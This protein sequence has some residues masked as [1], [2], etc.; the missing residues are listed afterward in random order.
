MSSDG[1]LLS[2]DITPNSQTFN[3]KIYST[4][5]LFHKKAFLYRKKENLN[6][7]DMKPVSIRLVQE[8]S[9]LPFY[10]Q[11][12]KSVNNLHVHQQVNG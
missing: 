3:L 5:L 2:P 10:S 12:P 4:E 7:L 8:F 9:D 11:K 6:V 1:L